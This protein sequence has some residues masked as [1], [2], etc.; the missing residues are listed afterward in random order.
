MIEKIIK[1]SNKIDIKS[2][3]DLADRL[4]IVAS[5]MNRKTRSPISHQNLI[6]KF[7]GLMNMLESEYPENR[8]YAK[9]KLEEYEPVFRKF[10]P[11][12]FQEQL[13]MDL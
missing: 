8:A 7:N 11:E 3:S 9:A 10:A 6:H 2:H 4:E 1:L 12:L 13:E 5:I